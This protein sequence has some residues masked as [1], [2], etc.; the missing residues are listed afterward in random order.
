MAE[1]EGVTEE[2]KTENQLKWAGL[3]NSIKQSAEEIVMDKYI[4]NIC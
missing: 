3:M 2:L 4:F 1:K